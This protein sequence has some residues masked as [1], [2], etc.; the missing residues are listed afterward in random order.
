LIKKRLKTEKM[1]DEIYSVV[2]NAEIKQC[3]PHKALLK[4][5]WTNG[6]IRLGSGHFYAHF[7][8]FFL[9]L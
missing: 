7:G 3:S 1:K 4:L 6:S 9:N 8:R 5:G 2:F